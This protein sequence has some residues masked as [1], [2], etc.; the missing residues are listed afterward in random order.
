MVTDKSNFWIFFLP[1]PTLIPQSAMRANSMSG[2]EQNNFSYSG[3][4][5]CKQVS[6]QLAAR[7]FP[8]FSRNRKLLQFSG[9]FIHHT[10]LTHTQVVK[11]CK[12]L[13][14]NILPALIWGKLNV[15]DIITV[16]SL[17]K[18]DQMFWLKLWM[19]VLQIG[20]LCYLLCFE[21]NFWYW[22]ESADGGGE[23][24][25]WKLG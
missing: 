14:L 17:N 13:F 3:P 2:R 25:C 16:C 22:G 5:T 15:K 12:S 7:S 1:F 4:D 21:N 9:S 20:L 24:C 10:W 19:S 18:V 11:S 6:Y 8:D 23:V